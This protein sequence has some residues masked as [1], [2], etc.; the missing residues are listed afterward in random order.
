MK[1][2]M[3]L[4]VKNE[5][6][7]VENNIRFHAMQGVDAFLVMDNGSEDGTVEI[8]KRLSMEY[9]L[10]IVENPSTSYQQKEWMTALAKRARKEMQADLVISNDADEFW[11]T[12]DGSSL[13]SKLS[14]K[15]TVVT[16]RRYNFVLDEG[17]ESERDAYITCCNRVI[18]PILY[19]THDYELQKK[20]SMP[21][22]KISPKVI[23]NPRGLRRISGGNHRA[24]H[25][26]FWRDRFSDDIVVDHYPIRSF[27]EFESKILNRQRL[28]L[29]HPERKQSAHYL[30]WLSSLDKG[31]LM[32]EY[33]Q[34]QISKQE[35]DVLLRLGVLDHV[36][37]TALAR[38]HAAW[39]VSA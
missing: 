1:L 8:L 35:R 17:S 37:P 10:T 19:G 2:V 33:R 6:D 21:L 32:Q 30:R 38:W 13:K 9:E 25:L 3:T 24:D 12:R 16:V 22:Q 7:I 15:D 4:L 34:M 18:N 14:M 26:F 36:E 29:K 28:R 39:K 31:E 20:M 5:Q 11:S 23:V 27:T